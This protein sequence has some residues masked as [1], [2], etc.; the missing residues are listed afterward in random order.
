[1]LF[2]KLV[3]RTSDPWAVRQLVVLFSSVLSN[4]LL[5]VGILGSLGVSE[6]PKSHFVPRSIRNIEFIWRGKERHPLLVAQSLKALTSNSKSTLF[7]FAF[8]QFSFQFNSD[9]PN[10]FNQT[11]PHKLACI[12]D[13]N[14]M[15]WWRLYL[16]RC[17]DWT[18][19]GARQSLSGIFVN[20]I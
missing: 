10:L 13:G 7:F 20:L 17:K 2:G 19:A 12:C 1:M 6:V 9:Y 16:C 8:F 5:Q 3:R 11:D 15:I 4:K 14:F 18:S